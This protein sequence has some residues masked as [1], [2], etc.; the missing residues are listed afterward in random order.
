MKI[1]TVVA[2]FSLLFVISFSVFAASPISAQQAKERQSIGSI[3]VSE[4]NSSPVDIKEELS[5]KADKMGA[6]AYH[7]TEAREGNSWHATAQI[8]K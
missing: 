7:I 6:T 1:K 5:Q 3:S 4:I 2:A 8:Y